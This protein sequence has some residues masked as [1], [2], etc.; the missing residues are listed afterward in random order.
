MN[1]EEL[2]VA[3]IRKNY[4]NKQLAKEL[5]IEEATLYLKMAGKTEFTLLEVRKISDILELSNEAFRNIFLIG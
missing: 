2:R 5:G 1:R 4:T 3:I